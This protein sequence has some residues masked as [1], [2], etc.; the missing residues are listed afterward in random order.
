[1]PM[2]LTLLFLESL[3][4]VDLGAL[5]ADSHELL[6]PQRGGGGKGDPRAIQSASS[7]QIAH[8]LR[9]R[10]FFPLEASH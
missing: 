4:R 1:M 6:V 2:D 7:M 3:N 8:L 5:K 9:M 10:W